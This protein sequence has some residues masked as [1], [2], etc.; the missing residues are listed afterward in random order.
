MCSCCIGCVLAQVEKE[1][2]CN[3]ECL[4][5]VLHG[6]AQSRECAEI[7]G[8]NDE[9]LM[10]ECEGSQKDHAIKEHEEIIRAGED[11]FNFW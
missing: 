7:E 11:I 9:T 1:L 5:C 4:V 8:L 3:C 10:Q 2:C 6:T